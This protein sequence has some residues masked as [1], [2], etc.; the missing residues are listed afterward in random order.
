MGGSPHP[1]KPGVF[2]PPAVRGRWLST[3][4]GTSCW[5]F[6]AYRM[7]HDGG[8]HF[9]C[10]S[11]VSSLPLETTLTL[12]SMPFDP[13]LHHHPWEEPKML[14]YLKKVDEKYPGSRLSKD[15]LHHH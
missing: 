4:L 6:I 12:S 11:F 10:S 13:Q 9:V 2:S 8:H 7:Y 5:F 14:E 1:M 3:L 15:N